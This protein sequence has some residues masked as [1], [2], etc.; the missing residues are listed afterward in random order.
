MREFSENERESERITTDSNRKS[1][2]SLLRG[3]ALLLVHVSQ[4]LAHQNFSQ[5][6]WVSTK[7]TP[8][9]LLRLHT[10]PSYLCRST[11]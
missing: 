9:C 5:F 10:P 8:L 3:V 11:F 4:A 1:F 7:L 6:K 2:P